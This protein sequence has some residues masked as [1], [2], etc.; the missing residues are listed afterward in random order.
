MKLF[1]DDERVPIDDDWIIFRDVD[2]AMSFIKTGNFPKEMSL[3]HDLGTE[4]TGYD[5]IKEFVDFMLDN[6][7]T[8]NVELYVHSQNPI[9]KKNIETYWKSYNQNKD[10]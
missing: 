5:F 8:E 4:K 6:N 9:G 1:L 2:S 3:D 7:I 10:T